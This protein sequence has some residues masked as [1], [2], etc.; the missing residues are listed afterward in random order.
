MGFYQTESG[1]E[2]RLKGMLDRSNSIS[3]YLNRNLFRQYQK[4]Q[5]DRW[6]TE[7]ASEGD[8]WEP[9]DPTYA[10]YKRKKFA[11]YP[12]GGN[13]TMVATGKL[14]SAAQAENPA[15]YYKIVTNSKFVIGINTGALPYAQYPGEHRPYM[16]FSD[17]HIADM[18]KGISDYI[19]KNG[20]YV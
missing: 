19:S 8:T 3:S 11:S 6:K 10:K 5:I 14:A 9:I 1:I 7:N 18:R 13:V 16:S 15:Y 17:D 12:G 2:Q 4:A 20:G